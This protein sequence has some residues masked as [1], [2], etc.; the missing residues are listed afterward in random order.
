MSRKV[1][2]ARY[3][4]NLYIDMDLYDEVYKIRSQNEEYYHFTFTDMVHEL[5]R[6][7][8]EHKRAGK[9]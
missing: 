6:L 9:A 1:K 5:L 3:H 2:G 8:I 7:G 4:A